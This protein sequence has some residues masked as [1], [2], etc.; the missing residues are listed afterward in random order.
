[1]Q[2]MGN[3]PRNF[4]NSATI[5]SQPTVYHRPPEPQP[6]FRGP[7]ITVFVGNISERV[8]EALLKRILATC[9][10]VINWK[11]VS[12]FGFCE[13]EWVILPLGHWGWCKALWKA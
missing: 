6:Q 10:V 3:P 9:G 1:M 12:T 8:P 4:R 7:I 11:R 5:S 13:F 2:N